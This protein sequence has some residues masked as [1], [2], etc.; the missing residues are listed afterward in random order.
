V[1]WKTPTPIYAAGEFVSYIMSRAWNVAHPSSPSSSATEALET[2]RAFP[3][4]SYTGAWRS[5]DAG[6]RR[7]MGE[8][9]G[10]ER[11]RC[12]PSSTTAVMVF[13]YPKA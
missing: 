1:A 5:Q 7:R 2:V 9:S 11:R 12:S 3:R 10:G 13:N 6:Q 4:I 8:D